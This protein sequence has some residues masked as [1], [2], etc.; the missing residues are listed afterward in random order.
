MIEQASRTLSKNKKR[1]MDETI[2]VKQIVNTKVSTVPVDWPAEDRL[3]IQ[4]LDSDFTDAATEIK[5][6]VQASWDKGSTYR[7]SDTTIWQG[8]AK[9][10]DGASPSL[11]LGP[12][13]GSDGKVNNPTTLKIHMEPNKG[14]P[15]LG[16]KGNL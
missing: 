3:K 15:T 10:R 13:L 11:T 8:G 5:V 12:F 4:L 9:A 14:T 6:T 2:L 7:W 1:S 16:L